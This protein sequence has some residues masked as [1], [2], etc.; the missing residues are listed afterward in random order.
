MILDTYVPEPSVLVE[1]PYSNIAKDINNLVFID[2][3]Q[4]PVYYDITKNKLTSGKSLNEKYQRDIKNLKGQPH[5]TKF[6]NRNNWL[7]S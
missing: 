1:I 3:A 4:N 2:N 7:G 5:A 6:L